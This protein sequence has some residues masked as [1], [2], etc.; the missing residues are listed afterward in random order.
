MRLFSR[1]TSS[2][3]GAAGAPAGGAPSPVDPGALVTTW[4]LAVDAAF[5][6]ESG[7]P[8]ATFAT[9]FY[10]KPMRFLLANRG[11]H[12]ALHVELVPGEPKQELEGKT[13]WERI[14]VKEYAVFTAT[15]RLMTDNRIRVQWFQDDPEKR[16][17]TT[18]FLPST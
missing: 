18:L 13:S 16:Y 4:H 3:R 14:G 6:K 8:E 11:P 2:S 17:F 9:G 12:D 5:K 7:I 1:P 10:L 15:R